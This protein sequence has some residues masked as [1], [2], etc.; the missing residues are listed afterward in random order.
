[1]LGAA[2]SASLLFILAP[3]ARA[4]CVPTASTPC[5]TPPPT[6]TPVNAFL[7]LDVTAGGPNTQ[8]TVN[9]GA[10][11]PNEQMTLYWDQPNKVAGGAVADGSGNFV[12]HVKP[13][14]GDSPGVHRLCASVP[15]SPC[16]NFTIEAPATSPS[17]SPTP[18]ESPSPSRT[19]SP[20]Q[21]PSPT[22]VAAK[23][24]GFDVISKPPFV[25]LPIFGVFAILVS[26]GYWLVSLARRPRLK[27]LPSAAVVHRAMRPDY[28]AGFGTP[29][30]SPAVEQ[31]PES[32][33]PEPVPSTEPAAPPPEAPPEPEAT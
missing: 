25:F 5:P 26:L 18:T 19:T 28:S 21:S 31:T 29:P 30:P 27:P 6:P 23:L 32:A 13:F 24:S 33:W 1:M 4:D 20:E 9:G 8:I 16:A 12:T 22:P 7:S 3:M 17:P 15:P 10:F 14:S 2:A 11:L